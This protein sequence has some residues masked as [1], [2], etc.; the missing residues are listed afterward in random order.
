MKLAKIAGVNLLNTY[1]YQP[2]ANKKKKIKF[3]MN[4]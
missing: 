4:F 1:K 2:I 3:L